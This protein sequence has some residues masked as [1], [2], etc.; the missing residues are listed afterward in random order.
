MPRTI[1]IDPGH[2]G[3]AK[4]GGSS[5]NNATGPTGLKEKAVTLDVGLRVA[6]HP[7]LAG[8]RVLMTRNTD[9][10]I[11]INQ[12][13]NLARTSEA[14]VFVSI[15]FNGNVSPAVQGTES[16]V[17][18]GSPPR[19]RLLARGT[20]DRLVQANGLRNRGV[21]TSIPTQFGVINPASHDPATA[22]T[23]V[24]VSFMT[25]PVE[26]QRLRTGTYLDSIA[27]AIALGIDHYMQAAEGV[28]AAPPAMRG[29]PMAK[30]KKAKSKA[31]AK[32]K[33]PRAKVKA[34][35][36]SKK[37]RKSGA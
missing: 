32:A 31:K 27:G 17:S 29:R 33:K 28:P 15:H 26:E 12:R 11:G 4:V 20:L 10:N 8:Y 14:E 23:L 3:I 13:A 35:A 2:G 37:R 16:W 34:R 19:C 36:K 7:A 25:D 30:K 21:R 6:G 5:P 24:E 18:E 1:V 22:H 9:I